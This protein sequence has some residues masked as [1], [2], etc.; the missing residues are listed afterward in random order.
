MSKDPIEKARKLIETWRAENTREILSRCPN[1][2]AGFES[3]DTQ[4]KAALAVVEWAQIAADEPDFP[5]IWLPEITDAL[6]DF[7][8][9]KVKEVK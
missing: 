7:S 6:K 5:E 4:H 1:I 3:L 2:I 9:L 8:V